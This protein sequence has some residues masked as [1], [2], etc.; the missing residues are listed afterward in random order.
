MTEGT[1]I[2]VHS[3]RERVDQTLIWTWHRGRDGQGPHL[4]TSSAGGIDRTH[5]YALY[6]EEGKAK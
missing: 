1:L 2:Y 3:I 5:I 6:Q 4:Y